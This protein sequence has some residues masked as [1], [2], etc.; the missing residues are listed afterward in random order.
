MFETDL[1][2]DQARSN[3]DTDDPS[4]MDFT[5]VTK[6]SPT[7][8]APSYDDDV[9]ETIQTAN[10]RINM[11]K[12]EPNDLRLVGGVTECE[13]RVEV[14]QRGEWGTVCDHYWGLNNA[15]V[16]CKQLD[17]SNGDNA[18]IR[19]TSFGA[20]LGRI[21]LHNVRC[22]GNESAL[23]DCP[24][25]PWEENNCNHDFDVGVSCASE[26]E[27]LR[28]VGGGT[29][30]EGRVEVKLRGEWGPVC[31][32][33]WSEQDA[34]VACRQLGCS[35]SH[36][37]NVPI[38][39]IEYG[40]RSG[41]I[42]LGD[43]E[44]TG[45][46]SALR[47]C[48]HPMWGYVSC[49]HK[50]DV[51]V[52]CAAQPEELR[53]VGGGTECEG[54]VE[55][56]LRGEWGTVCD[57]Y[58]SEQDANA[59]CRQLGCSNSH[60]TNVPVSGTEY[61]ASYGRIWLSDVECTGGESALWECEH[62]MWGYVRY[63]H[64]FDVGVICADHRAVRLAGELV[65]CSGYL[66]VRHG[67]TWGSVCDLDEELRAASVICRELCCGAALLPPRK[68]RYTREAGD[69]WTE[70]YECVG[71]ETSL[72]QCPTVSRPEI[73][74]SK[75]Y[76]PAVH[77]RGPFKDFKMVNSSSNCSGR[78]ELLYSGTDEWGTICNSHWDLQAANVLCR[79]LH[80]GIAKSLTDG[81][82]FG[83]RNDTIWRDRFHCEGTESH[84]SEC[85]LTALGN[86]E[87]PL[88][89]TA[90][91]ICTG[92][93]E[94]VRL[95]DGETQCEGR[96]E[97]L[98]NGTWRR[99][100]DDQWD[101]NQARVVCSKLNC[102]DDISTFTFEE[103]TPASDHVTWK[104]IMCEGNETE[105]NDC[106]TTQPNSSKAST[107]QK[108]TMG[109]ICSESKRLRLAGGPGRCAGRVE[110]YHRGQWGTVC[111][112]FWD[113]ADGDVVCRQ[114]KCGHAINATIMSYHGGGA[115]E[116]WLDDLKCVGNETALW[117]CN[118][119]AWGQ[120]NCNHK[121]DAGVI[122]SE[123]TD[124]RLIGGS[125]ACEGRLEVYYNGTWG[126]VCNNIMRQVSVSVICS[127][128]N[129]GTHGFVEDMYT[130][131]HGKEPYWVDH[132]D[133]RK[134]DESLW[135]CPSSAWSQ[136]TCTIR[137]TAQIKCE[138]TDLNIIFMIPYSSFGHSFPF[139]ASERN[140]ENKNK[141]VDC[142]SPDN[143]T[144]K[145]RLR[146]VGGPGIC[147]GRVE[148]FFHGIWGTVCDDSWD[149]KDAEVVCKHLGCGSAVA[150]VGEAMFGYGT[151]PIWMDE[152]N[153]KGCEELLQDCH[154][155]HWNKSDCDHKEDAGVICT[156]AEEYP[157]TSTL[158]ASTGQTTPVTSI[159]YTPSVFPIVL[160]I[161]LVVLL[162]LGMIAVGILV[163][164]LYHYR[165]ALASLTHYEA[166]YEE[167]D[168]RLI[169]NRQESSERSGHSTVCGTV[170]PLFVVRSLHSLWYGHST[171]CGTV[172][173]QLVVHPSTVC[174]NNQR[175]SIPKL[176]YY[177]SEDGISEKDSDLNVDPPHN[178]DDA[179]GAG[180]I[181]LTEG[182]VTEDI[183]GAP[184][185]KPPPYDYDDVEETNQMELTKI[186]MDKGSSSEDITA[187]YG[188]DEAA[189]GLLLLPTEKYFNSPTDNNG[190]KCFTTTG[191]GASADQ[192]SPYGYDDVELQTFIPETRG[193]QD[194]STQ[195]IIIGEDLPI[196]I[197]IDYDDAEEA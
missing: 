153:C 179:E 10:I 98:Q 30:C 15:A 117:K 41:R 12:G 116:I 25:Q 140:P 194:L 37:T 11:E 178:Y 143:C 129:C 192:V 7:V 101:I 123:F 63:D 43:V 109:V 27:E 44:C 108:K 64:Q 176:E 13:G 168:H 60:G 191:K 107:N 68:D 112:D 50:L 2:V 100:L 125:H 172:T 21:W 126:S 103:Q 48:K 135:Q 67:G 82:Y 137:E 4:S 1:E 92:K 35:N 62:P 118:S 14:K 190:E 106:A 184:A 90:G 85:S 169:R 47:E 61:G 28:L 45:E 157:P 170:T 19:A 127:Q 56:K 152:V 171:A 111:D 131:G 136:N 84:L 3:E 39:G 32:H 182:S 24:H 8:K 93:E 132:I 148:I 59:V 197:N 124:F 49:D 159:P 58:W 121:E 142:P 139:R 195:N 77:C 83:M 29:E 122:C 114:L 120:H 173:P 69:I 134:N 81:G 23:W 34:N 155:L 167:I 17:C 54:R 177:T 87:C 186:N 74:C 113:Q 76:Y 144:D 94:S 161:V 38:S 9:E 149:I 55:V 88:W 130:Y 146:L 52:I 66:E 31:D 46:E 79:Q 16:V 20:G 36:G 6:G 78:V 147:S 185:D 51:G 73:N 71:N 91:V 40:A 154:S 196:S 110:L 33:Y 65:S 163:K 75:P 26:P 105:L 162:G 150:A 42:W 18:T 96:L 104:S 183:N 193:F 181:D 95:V 102:G 141:I 5:S 165:K 166:V 145:D 151:G 180:S 189:L 86:N 175:N 119:S 187:D 156:G 174:A 164:C 22:H 115:G 53:L 158:T 72:F 99:V 80:C 160:C 89:D 138:Y 188:Y 70:E 97:A 57:Y 133:C 128:L